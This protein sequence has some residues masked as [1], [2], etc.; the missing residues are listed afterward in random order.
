MKK[1]KLVSVIVLSVLLVTAILAVSVYSAKPSSPPG[2][3]EPVTVQLEGAIYGMGAFTNIQITLTEEFQ[4]NGWGPYSGTY[5]YEYGGPFVANPD[6]PPALTVRGTPNSKELSY[7]YCDSENVPHLVNEDG[8]C[9][10][11]SHNPYNYKRL[12]IFGGYVDKKTGDI[13][14]PAGSE[15]SIGWKEYINDGN[16]G[17]LIMGTLAF[18]VRYTVLEYNQ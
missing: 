14:W 16:G 9:A 7:Y 1:T 18:P 10:D 11:S 17:R 6:Y 3:S 2:K 5:Y 15:W 4:G 8:T 13:V 12:R